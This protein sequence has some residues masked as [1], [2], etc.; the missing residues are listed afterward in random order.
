VKEKIKDCPCEKEKDSYHIYDNKTKKKI[1]I[2][3]AE[4]FDLKKKRDEMASIQVS[5]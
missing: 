2:C 4:G 1:H 3:G 5:E